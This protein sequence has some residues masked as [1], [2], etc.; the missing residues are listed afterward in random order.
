MKTKPTGM[1]LMMLGGVD[2]PASAGCDHGYSCVAGLR[3]TRV[4][5]VQGLGVSSV[6]LL[7]CPGVADNPGPAGAF[8]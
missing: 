3:K 2:Q 5:L 1:L 8:L 4:S 7:I 6:H